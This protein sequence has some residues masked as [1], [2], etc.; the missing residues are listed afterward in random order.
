MSKPHK[1]TLI[2]GIAIFIILPLLVGLL[3][4]SRVNTVLHTHVENRVKAQGGQQEQLVSQQFSN[5]LRELERVAGYFRDGAVSE[6]R[7]GGSA[8]RL[9]SHD[10]DLSI[11]IVRI[12]GE[13]VS[14]QALRPSE[15]PAIRSTFRGKSVVRY[16]RGEGL[17]FTVPIY[18]NGN[19][20]YALY[21]FY[22][23]DD[24]FKDFGRDCFD[25][26]AQFCL[27]DSSQ[28]ILMPLAGSTL[29]EGD[30]YFRREEVQEAI[31]K[32]SER[33]NLSVSAAVCCKTGGREEILFASELEQE[34]LYLIGIVPYESVAGDLSV[35][36]STMVVVF[37]LLLT[38]LVIGTIRVVTA[39][40]RARES[41]EL[42][43][44]KRVAEEANATK[45]KF[46]ANMSHEL[47]TPINTIL[48]MNEMILRETDESTTRERA[49]DIKSAAQI[50]LGLIN[51]VLDF[52]K[53]ESGML[54]IVPAEYNLVSLIR[55]LALLSED[56]ARSKSLDFEMEIQPDLPI[57]L[58]GDDVRLQQVMT[59]LLTNAV[60]YTPAGAVTLRLSGTWLGE[61]SIR[62]H[63][64]V[65]DTGIG[66]KEEDMSKLFVPYLR[67]DE[68]RNRKT[69]GT[70]LGL[71]II[72]NLLKLM[73]SELQV[74][75]V[76]GEGST[77]YFDLEQQVVD[78]E[79]VGSIQKRLED[80][81]KEYEYRVSCYAPKAR[82]L[83]VDDNSMNRRVF[84]NLL[85]QTKIQVT[86][87]SSGKKCLD[88][89]QK[90]HF[91]LIFMD[92][93][94]P[95]MDGVE[96]LR[97]LKEMGEENLCKDTPVIALTANAFSGAREKY[98]SLGFDAFLAKPINTEKLEGMLLNMLPKEYLETPPP[99]AV[100]PAAQRT[101]NAVLEEFPVVE[102]VNWDFALFHMGDAQLLLD[103]ARGF[104]QTIDAEL[105]EIEDLSGQV[106]TEEGLATYRTRVHALK[107]MSAT[108]GILSV[109]ELARMLER[110][111]REGSRERIRT[112]TPLLLEELKQMRDRLR[113]IMG[114]A[115]TAKELPA[116]GEQLPELLEMLRAALEEMDISSADSV[117]SQIKS[118]SYAPDL[119]EDVDQMAGLV[120]ELDFD[121]AGEVLTRLLG[122]LSE[123]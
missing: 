36:S 52:S 102:G 98:T 16:R 105:R 115:E 17:L 30:A 49:M 18:N 55:D 66:I 73:G 97:H 99:E 46:L 75:S 77:F 56:R 80:G 86:A 5:R 84:T 60:K 111:A 48:G 65:A 39:D 32:L 13:P 42:R 87:V 19:I 74:K 119:Q 68:Q 96:T 6:E 23:E 10:G 78:R 122:S 72:I 9:I 82:V 54:A 59:N 110:A 116:G 90:E 33:L 121:G 67:V 26:Q 21:K 3:M 114:P 47:R 25:G 94:M 38:L 27:A 63:C 50:L 106:G 117:M 100:R 95:D 35:L 70:G 8:R 83:V 76:Y 29:K 34:H 81:V 40:A 22:S 53:I 24:L 14:G 101:M 41:D 61:D 58:Y 93:L 20:K 123:N 88:L 71:S 109:S 2:S 62:L 118:F 57:G 69:E 64:E 104:C 79:P 112:L 44:A 45:G 31:S 92:H 7:M 89:V 11:G 91:D 43:E 107:S 51:D 108:V 103:T 28:R 120:S 1:R 37:I 85:R 12:D 4:Y 15:Y 113:P